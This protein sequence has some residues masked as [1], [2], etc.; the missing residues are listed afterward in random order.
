[1]EEEKK[2][3]IIDSLFILAGTLND[4]VD[5]LDTVTD[6]NEKLTQK[7]DE[8]FTKAREDFFRRLIE[9]EVNRAI[10]KNKLKGG[11][12]FGSNTVR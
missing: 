4:V 11:N 5:R 10:E 8:V 7:N 9:E 12:K 1:M 6:R 2:K 3:T